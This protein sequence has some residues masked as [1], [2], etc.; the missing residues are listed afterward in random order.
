MSA[1]A[2]AQEW[3]IIIPARNEEMNIARCLDSLCQ[4]NSERDSF[5]VLVCDNGSTDDTVALAQKYAGKLNLTV[6]SFPGLPIGALRNA[7]ARHASRRNLA[8]L[9]ADCTV[10]PDW[11][12][13][14][15][16]VLDQCATAVIGSPYAL[17]ESAGWP[18]R[19]WH[20]RF[21]AGREGEVSYIP[22]GNLLVAKSL[23]WSLRGFDAK[24]R[25]NEDSQFCSRARQR[26]IRVLAFPQL[27]AIH[28]GAEK[29]L[30]H[31]IR[32]QLWHGSNVVN[33][34]GLHGNARAIGLAMY[35]FACLVVL[36]AGIP[37]ADP[38][39]IA[40]AVLAM[41]LPP[42]CLA[43]RGRNIGLKQFGPL[44]FLLLTYGI[45]RACVLPVA[46][47]RG[48]QRLTEKA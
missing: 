30:R 17:P 16:Q 24:L 43:L 44:S 46:V 45:V 19:L 2:F 38:K 26:G 39:L 21:H 28:F 42:L 27:A 18:A 33:G 40:G 13:Q 12:E 5:E 23:F 9:D 6:L 48:M 47:F 36:L 10:K 34:R 14:A 15:N 4:L 1:G 3:S 7:G 35:T 37:L 31:F 8:F 20:K 22:A 25:S 41:L 32:R 11:V 29:D